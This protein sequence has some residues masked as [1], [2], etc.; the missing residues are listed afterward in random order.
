[1]TDDEYRKLQERFIDA[2]ERIQN[3]DDY[4]DNNRR[5][6]YDNHY[7]TIIKWAKKDAEERAQKQA[8]NPKRMTFDDLANEYSGNPRKDYDIDL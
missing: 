3:L 8:Q 7:L 2:E 4:L 6:H 1:M 5:K